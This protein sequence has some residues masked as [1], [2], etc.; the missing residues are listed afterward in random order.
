MTLLRNKHHSIDPLWHVQIVLAITIIIQLLIPSNLT[1]FPKLLLP[2]LILVC[3]AGMQILTPR[4][5]VFTSRAR[6][7]VVI[8]LIVFVAIA[9]VSSL[10]LLINAMLHATQVEAPSLL[11]SAAGIYLTNIIVFGLLY[12]EMDNGGPG[13]RRSAK[14]ENRDFLFP[15]QNLGYKISP[16]WYPTFFDY[17]YVSITNATAFSPTDSMPLSRRSKFVM[18]AQALI[19]LLSIVLVAARAINIL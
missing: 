13:A 3:M 12:W 17:L 11:L 14:V 7:F 16:I 9:N 5:A 2:F 4:T 6:R 1:P 19:S 8:G 15:Q 18:S 10:Q